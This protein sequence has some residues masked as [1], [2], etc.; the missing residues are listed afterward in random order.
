[1]SH[2]IFE[3]ILEKEL[4]KQHYYQKEKRKKK[5]NFC[6]ASFA[7]VFVLFRFLLSAIKVF[8]LAVIFFQICLESQSVKT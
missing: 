7:Q 8:F 3:T 4:K 6:K 2:L 1:V 5:K